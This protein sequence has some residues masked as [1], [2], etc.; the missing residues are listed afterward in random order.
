MKVHDSTLLCLFLLFQN[1][2][3]Q[4]FC[5]SLFYGKHF[6]SVPK[7]LYELFKHGFLPPLMFNLSVDWVGGN[8]NGNQCES[9]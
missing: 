6:G 5:I 9:L 4:K 1:S 8:R 7:I 3:F 2:I